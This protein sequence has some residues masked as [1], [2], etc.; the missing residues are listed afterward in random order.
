MPEKANR[1]KKLD[2]ADVPKRVQETSIAW[3]RG[4]KQVHVHTTNNSDICLLKRRGW[5]AVEGLEAEAALPYLIFRLPRRALTIR[6][7]KSVK[8]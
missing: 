1:K 5:E 4:Q 8:G 2:A 3:Y 6:S 7:K